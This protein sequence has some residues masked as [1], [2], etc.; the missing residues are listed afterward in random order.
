MFNKRKQNYL[1]FLSALGI[2]VLSL[3][4]FAGCG[5]GGGGTSSTTTLTGAF[6]DDPVQG[7]FYKT[8]TKSGTTDGDGKFEYLQGEEVE[9][10]VGGLEGLLLGKA[11][12]DS[13][14][15]PNKIV[16]QT[17]TDLTDAEKEN[18]ETNILRFIQGLNKSDNNMDSA[19]KILIDIDRIDP[20]VLKKTAKDFF[21]VSPDNFSVDAKESGS[22]LALPTA[23]RA[24][25]RHQTALKKKEGKAAKL[26][27][28]ITKSIT[29]FPND[30]AWSKTEGNVV[31]ALS[32]EEETAL[33]AD[34][35]PATTK[36]TL[37]SNKALFTAF[38]ALKVK[39]FSP[40]TTIFIPLETT[41]KLNESN[42]A[43]YIK[44]YDLSNFN[45]FKDVSIFQSGNQIKIVPLKPLNA[46]AKY[47]VLI[48]KGI[49]DI[50]GKNLESPD[51]FNY[52]LK[53]ENELTGKLA[54]LEP[55]RKSYSTLFTTIETYLKK[56]K[57]D[58]L[59]F[60][61]LT[62]AHKTLSLTDF[63]YVKAAAL[64]SVALE[65][66]PN[67]ISGISYNDSNANN[68]PDII[69]E[70]GAIN[71]GTALAAY[72]TLKS[73]NNVTSF[74]SY[75]ITTLGE[76]NKTTIDVNYT[77]INKVGTATIPYNDSIIIFQ[78]GFTGQKEHALGLLFKHT[79][80]PIIAMD[81]PEHGSRTAAG[82]TSGKDFLTT[83]VGQDRIN[84]YQSYFDMSIMLKNIKAGK[85]DFDRDNTKDTPAKI[86]FC[87]QSMGAI[88]GSV[89]TAQNPNDI[90]KIVLKVGG[91]SLTSI[92]DNASN[93]GITG[94]ME[95]LGL[96]KN[97]SKYFGTIGLFQTLLDP[98]DPVYLSND[99]IKEKTIILTAHKDSV[100]PNIS[101]KVLAHTI[102][103]NSATP[104]TDFDSDVA[105]AT[106]WYHY[107]NDPNR[108]ANWI[109]HSFVFP[110]TQVLITANYPE[111]I[112]KFDT[113]YIGKAYT[114]A[115]TQIKDFFK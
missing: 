42:F 88:T 66:L 105:S 83:N 77:I 78:H 69:E 36:A 82:K 95:P 8:A 48:T 98:A 3:V 97:T 73:E 64:G 58:I 60:F 79:S 47:L 57:D 96:T 107:G 23:E 108:N 62:T 17:Y 45:E 112:D 11:S 10:Y 32:A 59:E 100:V 101:N 12:G 33:K 81:L 75:D 85:F 109:P 9:F 71:A 39:G 68:T 70:Y 26:A 54:E 110:L 74:T 29:P 114:H 7:L 67:L 13:T 80:M 30:I 25:E 16:T 5:S 72:S 84:L 103:F 14:I 27:L 91:A 49:K 51:L 21:K 53:S 6:I 102:G 37:M 106:G 15:T 44:V 87:G 20:S 56:S 55:L 2:I 22:K 90:D 76:T 111:A 35:T 18:A 40:N 92:I 113:E 1:A 63:G 115:N 41:L 99:K 31:L 24:K 46:G 52:I 34:A 38:N 104:I 43:T 65:A 94:L 50:N 19:R 61:T 89:L 28:D 4:L 93:A 86:Y